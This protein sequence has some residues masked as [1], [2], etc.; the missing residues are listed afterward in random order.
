MGRVCIVFVSVQS[1][2]ICTTQHHVVN[3]L[4]NDLA[5]NQCMPSSNKI[6]LLVLSIY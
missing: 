6:Y 4:L 3:K 1:K 5:K 2:S